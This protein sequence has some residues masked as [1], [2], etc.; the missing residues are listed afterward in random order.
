MIR[1]ARISL[2]IGG[3]RS[4]V[5]TIRD[6]PTGLTIVKAWLTC[7]NK[8]NDADIAA[9]FQLSVTG[10]VTTA[11][12]VT[13]AGGSGIGQI[14]INIL[15]AQSNLLTEGVRY[16]YDIQLRYSSGTTD[17]IE[18]GTVIASQRVTLATS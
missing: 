18:E 13:D 15:A 10:T 1:D 3:D 5:R 16:A 17:T 11:G 14:V 4:I 8:L 2:K 9:V 7:K 12:Q 6:V